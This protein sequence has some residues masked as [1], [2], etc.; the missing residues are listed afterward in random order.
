MMYKDFAAGLTTSPEE[1]ETEIHVHE[2]A[3]DDSS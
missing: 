1:N 2:D 3:V